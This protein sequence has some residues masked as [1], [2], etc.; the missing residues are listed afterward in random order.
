MGATMRIRVAAGCTLRTLRNHEETE[1]TLAQSP[2][3]AW[4]S[5]SALSAGSR[6]SARYAKRTHITF[7][8]FRYGVFLATASTT[9]T[10]KYANCKS[11]RH[12]TLHHLLQ[13]HDMITDQAVGLVE[14][15]LILVPGRCAASSAA[16][17]KGVFHHT[18]R[19]TDSA[20]LTY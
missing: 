17:P 14:L 3:I 15:W 1:S 4:H 6:P 5:A 8:S 7:R 18:L 10:A 19:S 16:A 2:T 13:T 11:L 12:W 20:S 9:A